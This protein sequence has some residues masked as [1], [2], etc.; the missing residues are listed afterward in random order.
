MKVNCMNIICIDEHC[1]Y[2]FDALQK[3]NMKS[4]E[5]RNFYIKISE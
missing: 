5:H 2:V 1:I 3:Q 4:M